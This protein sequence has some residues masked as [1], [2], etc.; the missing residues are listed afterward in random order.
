[1]N[2]TGVG[3]GVA[4]AVGLLTAVAAMLV[5]QRIRAA[6]VGV[7]TAV[8]GAAGAA[9]GISALSGATFDLDLPDLLPLSGVV[10]TVDA[11]GGLFLAVTG[12]VAVAAGIYGIGYAR[13][14]ARLAHAVFPLFVVAML[15]VVAAGSVGTLLVCWELM[16]LSSLL[17]VVTEHQRGPEVAA[18]GR[19]Y[20]VMTHLGVTAILAGLLVLA[21]HATGD[22]FPALR[23][24]GPHLSPT[25]A[26]AVFLTTVA[27]FGS[28]AGIV[29]LHA[30]LPRAHPEAPSHVSALMSAAMVNLGV[31]GI[32]RVGFD[33]LGGGPRWW[34]AVVLGLG[35]V[36]A[37]YGILQAAMSTDLK[38]L[39]GYSTTEN[40][41]L[42]LVGVGAAGMFA[43]DGNR[44]LAGL[45]LAAAL[46]HV[47]NHAAFKTVLFLSAGSV[48]HGAGTRD[49]DALG[50]L[51]RSM[52]ATTA[53]FGLGALAAS[54]LPP[55][56]AFVSEW[57]LLQALIH[58][59]P[60]S[61]VITAI[62]M[63]LAVA[64]VALT[65]GLA[66]ATF[67]KAFGVGFL[68]RPRS[69]TAEDASESPASM[70]IGM[71]I[72]GLACVGLA[73]LPTLVL[74]AIGRVAGSTQTDVVTIQLV[75]AAGSL[76]PLMLAIALGAAIVLV[77]A[78]L[79]MAAARRVARLWD[80]GAGPL[81]ARMEYTATSFAEPLQRVFDDV[82]AP[83]TDVDVT[84]TQES[85]Y[86]V[87]AV[88]YRRRVPDRIERRLYQPVLALVAAW[89]SAG[90][91]LATGSV[92]RYL[93][94]GFYTACGLLILLVVTR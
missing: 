45:A 4:V 53:A 29:P 20:A 19:W 84:H 36:S 83:E 81:S 43:S 39:L 57:L 33:L 75:G 55:G 94:Y 15:L 18:A 67:V 68:A 9:A 37:V 90:R 78:V 61:G 69:A 66:V 92:H 52:P 56:T 30:W 85:S 71:G 47:V 64:A 44:V 12:G 89:G 1:M 7:G 10:I 38:R 14:T 23:A 93:G 2:P 80:C 5:P 70:L 65:A 35:A 76:S 74:P 26:A 54:A 21:A 40:M 59:L 73:L 48:L 63:P 34:W 46:L 16:A 82:L 27:G 62:A 50:G 28:K 25:V 31:Y 41:G 8:C 22:S 79:R 42:V 60:A 13:H 88:E 3:L 72:A 58:G 24:A 17:L 11:L 49:L 77:V 6:V 87:E 86:L 32:V 51:R 91:R